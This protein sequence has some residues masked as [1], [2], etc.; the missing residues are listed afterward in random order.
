MIKNEFKNLIKIKFFSNILMLFFILLC[1]VTS[2]PIKLSHVEDEYNLKFNKDNDGYNNES[3][4]DNNN[5]KNNV[6]NEGK[7]T[8]FT[9]FGIGIACLAVVIFI[10]LG[11]WFYCGSEHSMEINLPKILNDS[12]PT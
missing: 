6:D 7:F 10:A 1:D 9:F 12:S 11:I 5:D 8:F 3:V 2:I 4:S